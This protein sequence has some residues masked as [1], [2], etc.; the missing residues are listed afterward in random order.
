MA[1]T[2]AKHRRAI[3]GVSIAAALIVLLGGTY[4]TGHAMANGTMPAKTTVEGVPIGRMDHATAEAT[5]KDELGPKMTAPIT[6]ADH[7]TKVTIDPAKAGL[8]VDW[9]AT[10][11]RAGAKNSWNPATIWNTLL[12]GGPVPLQTKVDTTA[13]EKTIDKNAGAFAIDAKDA[14]VHL[15]G[16]KIVTSKA[17]QGRELDVPATAKSVETAWHQ[18]KTSV[19]ATVKRLSLIH[20]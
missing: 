18:M 3:I 20:I 19:P 15:D 4:L 14:T 11:D 17:V 10:M 9:D 6:V 7:G 8:V 2:S 1:Q 5:L 13:V 16:A 12:G